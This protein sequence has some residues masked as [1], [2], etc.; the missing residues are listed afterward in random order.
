MASRNEDTLQ[1]PPWRKR[2]YSNSLW[3]SSTFPFS[4]WKW[5]RWNGWKREKCLIG[6]NQR[7]ISSAIAKMRGGMELYAHKSI[8]LRPWICKGAKRRGYCFTDIDPARCRD[9][10]LR[11]DCLQ[12]VYPLVAELR[13]L[14]CTNLSFLTCRQ[15]NL[16]I[17]QCFTQKYNFSLKNLLMV[18]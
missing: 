4:P 11:P 13:A 6:R 18:T 17:F 10:G 8:S 3:K 12:G 7:S 2:V 5:K 14:P 16:F 1:Q 9:S 15:Y